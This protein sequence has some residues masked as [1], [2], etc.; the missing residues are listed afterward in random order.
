MIRILLFTT[1]I[2][3]IIIAA[4]PFYSVIKIRMTPSQHFSVPDPDWGTEQKNLFSHV[5]FL[6]QAI[7]SRSYSEPDKLDLARD[8]ILDALEMYGY[9]PSLQTY[10]VGSHYYSNII[11]LLPGAD[12]NNEVIIVGAH[13]D[14]VFGTPGADDNASAVAMLLETARLMA[15]QR[16]DRT[17]KLVFFTL[18]EPPNFGTGNMGSRVF[19]SK[20]RKAN[21]NI[22]AMICLE[23]VG[24]FYSERGRQAFPLPL[25]NLFYSSTPDFIGVVGNRKSAW[26]VERVGQ[27]LKKGCQVPVETLAAPSFIP[28]ISLSDH[29]SFW[30][31]GYPAVML[32]DTAFYRNPNY[33]K[34]SDTVDTL[35]YDVMAELLK[36][37]I[38]VINDLADR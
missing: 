31:E 11:V 21:M 26:L 33:H 9:S 16:L 20:A 5:K 19:A 13:Y 25:M 34:S 36:G 18:E 38:H 7:G 29:S 27:G 3:L 23:M 37:L 14:T 4:F 35:N 15:G 8:Y 24:Y 28:G 12:N 17:V 2:L 1:L 6:S 22:T 10:P 32:T 30:K